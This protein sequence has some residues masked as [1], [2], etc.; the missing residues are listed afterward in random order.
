MLPRRT[1][2]TKV[3]ARLELVG[4]KLIVRFRI[5]EFWP[6]PGGGAVA[7]EWNDLIVTC[8][9]GS[10]IPSLVG[11][12]PV[13]KVMALADP[14]P[15]K[16]L[17]FPV[18]LI[19][20]PQLGDAIVVGPEG[21]LTMFGTG[22]DPAGFREQF[23]TF[24]LL[25]HI[26]FIDNGAI[27]GLVSGLGKSTLSFV[28]DFNFFHTGGLVQGDIRIA[29][30]EAGVYH[31]YIVAD[32]HPPLAA[33]NGDGPPPPSDATRLMRYPDDLEAAAARLHVVLPERQDK[34]R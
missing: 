22:F 25:H 18:P 12:W 23:P 9:P 28:V 10:P 14:D 5:D 11:S 2:Y 31:A 3:A 33:G 29:W 19:R 27:Q 21:Q 16:D 8:D 1:L 13:T 17:P 26:L 4:A 34:R 15:T 24:D 20:R 32:P 30:P 6:G 7:L